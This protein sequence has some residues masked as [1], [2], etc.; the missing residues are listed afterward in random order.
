MCPCECICLHMLH[1]RVC[2]CTYVC[3][4]VYAYVFWCVHV[5]AY[6]YAYVSEYVSAY[7]FAYVCAYVY[8]Y[9]YAYV[10][11]YVYVSAYVNAYLY[12]CT[13]TC[14]C[15]CDAYGSLPLIWY[16]KDVGTCPGS[17]PD[18]DV[19]HR[20]L[21]RGSP[22]KARTWKPHTFASEVGSR[23][24]GCRHLDIIEVSKQGAPRQNPKSRSLPISAPRKGIP[25]FVEPAVYGP[26]ESEQSIA[27]QR[28]SIPV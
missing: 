27:P 4:H 2:M 1:V 8:E 14:M 25:Q 26:V 21:S 16:F 3:F 12:I 22:T 7:V 20:C 23:H 11:V 5:Y 13:C 24:G 28:P 6:V 19:W 18:P 15:T 9:V 10:Y 17:T